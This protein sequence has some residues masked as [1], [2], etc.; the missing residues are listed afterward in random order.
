MR[1]IR[2]RFPAAWIVAT[3]SPNSMPI[4][5]A[6]N[7]VD[8]VWQ[9][10]ESG[11]ASRLAFVRRVRAAR[12]DFGLTTYAHNEA[13]RVMK[14]A[15]V[16]IIAG[17]EGN[18]YRSAYTESVFPRADEHGTLGSIS[19]LLS[20]LG[21][22]TSDWR[23]ILNIPEEATRK[24]DSLSLPERFAA[25][26]AGASHPN[27]KWP[28]ERFMSVAN[29]LHS[30]SI[31]CVFV[32]GQ[33]ERALLSS[34]N[35]PPSAQV[36]AGELSVLEN[37]ALFAKARVLLTNDSGPMHLASLVDTPIVGLYGPS[38]PENYPPYGEGH[39]LLFVGCKNCPRTIDECRGDCWRG[40][41]AH[42]V[43]DAVRSALKPAAV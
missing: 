26:Q 40:I 3:T 12:F 1:W 16:R 15:G 39:T 24:V 21:C 8:E 23:P 6:C 10:P 42:V 27:K 18:K 34:Q 25:V 20:G 2:R 29:D 4:M 17:V 11:L 33:A 19:R 7:A 36:V 37:P 31:P 35:L 43:L 14:L 13:V 9:R 5:Q 41:E 22:D 28:L 32:G 38:S 30:E